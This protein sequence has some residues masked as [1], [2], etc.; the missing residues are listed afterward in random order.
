MVIPTSAIR[1]IVKDVGIDRISKDALEELRK[2]VEEI[3][4]AVALDAARNAKHAKRKT[5]FADDIKIAAG[6]K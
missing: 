4:S 5:I 3:G 2:G 6:K 1:K